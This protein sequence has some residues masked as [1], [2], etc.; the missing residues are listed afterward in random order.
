MT[1]TPSADEVFAAALALTDPSARSAYLDRTCAGKA[2][3]REEVES[4]L[5]AATRAGT[6]LES[7]LTEAA[8]VLREAS[9]PIEPPL[10]ERAGSRIGRYKL[11][12]QIGEGGFGVVW[13][14]EQEEPV[15]RRVAL[16]IIKLGMD[17]REVVA[18][19][20]AERQALALMDHPH[21]AK[22]LDGGATDKGR[23][24]FVMDLVKGVPITK[25]C[26]ERRLSTRQRLEL[27]MQVCHAV[28][29]AHQK[30]IIHRDLKPSNILVT[31]QDDR[32][33]P[34]VIDFG[35]AK[36]TQARLTEKTLFTRLQQWIGTPAYMS[37]E[38]AGLGSLDVD[39]R[40]DVY[41]LGVVLYELLTGR[42][43]FDTQKLLATGYEAVMR[44]IREEDPPKPST[45]LST[46]QEVELSTTA[47]QRGS[48]PAKLN[49]LV[50]GD[51]DWIVMKC[52][53]KDRARRY[54]TAS[55]LAQDLERHLGHEPVLARPPSNLYR[56]QKL[57]RRN[58]LAFAA[59]SL[60]SASLVLGLGISTILFFQ[61]R[62]ARERAVAAEQLAEQARAE[63]TQQ[64]EKATAKAQ[65]SLD[66]L[67]R[68]QNANGIARLEEAELAASLPWF[69]EALGA[70]QGKPEREELQ[71]IRI[72]S[73]LHECPKPIQMFFHDGPVTT[74]HF[75][76]NGRWV[77]TASR[78]HTARVWDPA[79]GQPVGNTLQHTGI[80]WQA[81]FSADGRR[82]ATASADGTARVWDAETGRPVTPPLAHQ[83]P[84]VKAIFS[85]DG[86]LVA[87]ACEDRTARLWD[88]E[89]GE[90]VA[91][92]KGHGDAVRQVVFS[93][94]GMLLATG[95]DDARV[96]IWPTRVAGTVSPAVL[97]YSGPLTALQFSASAKH[98]MGSS[99]DASVRTHVVAQGYPYLH[100][101]INYAGPVLHAAFSPDDRYLVTAL[102]TGAAR[103]YDA[104][105]GEPKGPELLHRGAIHSAQFDP[106]SRRVV[107][108]S[109]DQ[110]AAVWEI[111]TGEL[112]VRLRHGGGPN[113]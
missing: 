57:V 45:R 81:V 17:T 93:P 87:T 27:F 3:L 76:Q 88:A 85:P 53:E 12:E 109:A 104:L 65:E 92:I 46:L 22:V 79:T 8:V 48:E 42:T 43:P 18:R 50:R 113:G 68:L 39:T 107:T 77:V 67:V 31:V 101:T 4:L 69:A 66:R 58:K 96:R 89:S 82:V 103:V 84:V 102:G 112:V 98:F 20:E 52:L 38:Q 83:G 105:C 23:P 90:S 55:A 72:N 19:F 60:V 80:V 51:L 36:A 40:S 62:A 2:G 7:P 10:A 29:H 13:M 5:A 99:I 63:E 91:L 44:T 75:S 56:L 71:R 95:S 28:Q 30:G 97:L 41:S 16:K 24:Y 1:P 32:P 33:L 34:K 100:P 25:F 73:V 6:F 94:D 11:L 108:A 74:A 64:R 111:N 86:K 61:E 21:I 78:D 9:Q 37:P 26:D 70:L 35:V 110:T 59:G 54:E 106:E 14:A 49:R 47:V 15:R